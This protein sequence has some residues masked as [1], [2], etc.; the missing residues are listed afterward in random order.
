MYHEYV[1]STTSFFT[2]QGGLKKFGFEF[3]KIHSNFFFIGVPTDKI[4]D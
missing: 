4:C 1:F 3:V 2:T